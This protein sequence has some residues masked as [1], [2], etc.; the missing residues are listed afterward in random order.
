MEGLMNLIS[1]PMTP[2]QAYGTFHIVLM[3][4]GMTFCISMAWLCRRLDEKKNRVLLL[5]IAAC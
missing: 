4:V 3:I 1:A 2:P 5:S